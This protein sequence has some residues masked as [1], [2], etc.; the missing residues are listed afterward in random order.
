M[1]NAEIRSAQLSVNL[2]AHRLDLRYCFLDI[3][4][5]A[6]EVATFPLHERHALKYVCFFSPISHCP[7]ERECLVVIPSG[8]LQV[9]RSSMNVTDM[10]ERGC[11]SP[12]VLCCSL[13]IERLLVIFQRLLRL[14]LIIESYADA[15]KRNRLSAPV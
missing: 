12:A 9:T 4:A 6:D 10:F 5:R 15:I 8:S 11:L 1:L 2:P 13:K 14:A 7:G 3:F